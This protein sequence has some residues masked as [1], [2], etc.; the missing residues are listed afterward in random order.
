MTHRHPLLPLVLALG[1]VSI[2]TAAVLI[3][4][5]D[6]APPEVIAA[7]RLGIATVVL[8]PVAVGRRRRLRLRRAHVK[9]LVLAGVLLAAHFHFW[10]ASLKHTSVLSSVVIVTT[11]PLFVGLASFALFRER[12]GRGLV[13]AIG[14]SGLGGV[15]IALSDSAAAG[16][17]LYGDAL[18]LCGAVM[19]SSYFLVGRKIR[20]DLDTLSY[21]V[22]VYA[23][24]AVLLVAWAGVTGHG[25]GGYRMATYV[26]FVLLAVV[27]QLL[28]HG[29]LNWA[30]RYLPATTLSVFI[31]GE[32]I[33]STM[34]ARALLDEPIAPLQAAG[35]GLILAGILIASRSSAPSAP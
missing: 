23:V 17:T 4:L 30:L 32:P 15:L 11:N 3:K 2:S 34:L 31:L 13:V 24:A 27:P 14:V 12:V 18:A 16:G 29:S 35:G 8:T 1:V 25:F 26:Y 19:A 22:P 20:R 33:G 28:G 10:I 7:A 9:Y 5:C 6:D 21:I